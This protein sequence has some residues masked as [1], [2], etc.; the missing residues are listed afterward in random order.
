[1]GLR[2]TPTASTTSAMTTSTDT[3]LRST[4][5]E[6]SGQMVNAVVTPPASS[7]HAHRGRCPPVSACSPAEMT[8]SSNT[9][10][11]RHCAMFST[12]GTNDAFAP[13]RPRSSTMAGAPVFAPSTSEAPRISPPSAEPTTIAVTAAGRFSG[14]APNGVRIDKAPAKPEQADAEVAPEAEL[15]EQA[16]GAW[17]RLG[18]RHRRFGTARAGGLSRRGRFFRGW[19]VGVVLDEGADMADYLSLRRYEPD[20]VQAVGDPD[21]TRRGVTAEQA[22]L[23]ARSGSRGD[24]PTLAGSGSYLAPRADEIGNSL[25]LRTTARDFSRASKLIRAVGA[26]WCGSLLGRDLRP[27]SAEWTGGTLR[28]EHLSGD[29]DGSS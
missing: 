15:V 19:V 25:P 16:E 8:S 4:R 18:E 23:S 24:G 12:V 21:S 2:S 22:A 1:M 14:P 6:P 27:C 5:I 7:T 26:G 28:V 17:R 9:A 11:P 29:S 13:S 20:Q 10:Q 3:Y